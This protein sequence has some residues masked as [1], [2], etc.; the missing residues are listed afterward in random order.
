M[1]RVAGGSA[2]TV[3]GD[4]ALAVLRTGRLELRASISCAVLAEF[5]AEAVV[6]DA[7]DAIA[8]GTC[9]VATTDTE[10]WTVAPAAVDP[11]M[12]ASVNAWNRDAALDALR[13]RTAE[14][15][16]ASHR[17]RLATQAT[18]STLLLVCLY[19]ATLWAV[20]AWF[21]KRPFDSAVVSVPLQALFLVETLRFIRA[22]RLPAAQFGLTWRMGRRALAESLGLTAGLVA[23]LITAKAGALNWSGSPRSL[24]EGPAHL[25]AA[26]AS[27]A[28][29]LVIAYVVFSL[30]QEIVVRAGVQ[31][32]LELVFTG[33]GAR[34]W[35]LVIPSVLFGLMHLHLSPALALGTFAV[36]L[37]WGWLFRRHHSVL[38][39]WSS[40]LLLGG[41]AFFA[42]GV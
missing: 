24:F 8:D 6:V 28:A 41:F 32:G 4:T 3:T 11:E 20:L 23:L 16:A 33:P 40:H 15:A 38:A 14:L 18:I 21:P 35:A 12:T 10:L 22:S 13:R 26:G 25:R 17:A 39:V 1:V 37:T 19:T 31:R 36:S 7:S 9:L 5:Q 34:T 30:V 29:V 27:W 2:W 42:L